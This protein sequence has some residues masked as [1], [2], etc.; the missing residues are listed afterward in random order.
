ML[1]H[2]QRSN[3]ISGAT[4]ITASQAFADPALVKSGL[5]FILDFGAGLGHTGLVERV[6][7][8]G[9]LATIEGNTNND[10][11]RSGVGVFR[12]ERR[13]LNDPSLKGFVDYSGA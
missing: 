5:I 1:S 12:L 9:R 10:G 3:T 8:G 13:K 4:R 6:L 11:S 7:P 2:W